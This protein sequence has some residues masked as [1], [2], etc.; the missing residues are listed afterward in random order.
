MH[1]SLSSLILIQGLCLLLGISLN[2]IKWNCLFIIIYL[3]KNLIVV[4]TL[5]WFSL[6]NKINNRWNMKTHTGN[7]KFVHKCFNSEAAIKSTVYF[8]FFIFFSAI[9]THSAFLPCLMKTCS[10][11]NE[12]T[13]FSRLFAHSVAK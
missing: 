3:A 10:L 6:H 7:A 13:H 2:K 1:K 5:L 4:N 9:F 12:N 8:S 11:C